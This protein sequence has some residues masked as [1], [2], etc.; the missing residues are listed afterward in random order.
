M[1]SLS[2]PMLVM[3]TANRLYDSLAR[4]SHGAGQ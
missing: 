1:P 4:S 2:C 3:C